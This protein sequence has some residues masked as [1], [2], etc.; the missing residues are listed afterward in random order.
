VYK[1]K[2]LLGQRTP[3]VVIVGAVIF[4]VGLVVLQV[5]NK[6]NP[7]D[8]YTL[9][10]WSS[11]TAQGF[12]DSCVSTATRPG[13][14]VTSQKAKVYCGCTLSAMQDVYSNEQLLTEMQEKAAQAGAYPEEVVSVMQSCAKQADIPFGTQPS[15]DTDPDLVS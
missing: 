11:I 15:D 9:K 7:E 5:T 12:F 8:Y 1:I 4:L 3:I 13:S 10:A 14:N 2:K 6:D